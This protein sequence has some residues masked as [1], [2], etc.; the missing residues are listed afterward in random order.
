M[1]TRIIRLG[2]EYAPIGDATTILIQ[3][4]SREG[5]EFVFWPDESVPADVGDHPDAYGH[6]AR[7]LEFLP[8]VGKG[9]IFGRVPRKAYGQVAKGYCAVTGPPA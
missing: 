2:P 6:L 7:H 4:L 8:G 3:A 5:V 9:L 1:K